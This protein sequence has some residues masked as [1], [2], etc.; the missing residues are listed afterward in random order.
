MPALTLIKQVTTPLS[1][2]LSLAVVASMS[3]WQTHPA[4]ADS[5]QAEA[6]QSARVL[7]QPAA[8]LG[9]LNSAAG[10]ASRFV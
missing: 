8:L 9:V 10:K 1:F 6:T 3:S 7:D 2:F 5:E 4:E